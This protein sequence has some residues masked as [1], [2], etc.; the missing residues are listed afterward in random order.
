LFKD[1]RMG[2]V[3]GRGMMAVEPRIELCD[4]LG[5]NALMARSI[6]CTEFKSIV[7]LPCSSQYRIQDLL[8]RSSAVLGELA[9]PGPWH[10]I[11]V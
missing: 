3:H 7:R 6:S 1:G 11:T 2:P 8:S 5:V 9:R 10:V 4:L